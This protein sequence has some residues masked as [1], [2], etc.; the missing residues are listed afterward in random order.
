MISLF[1]SSKLAEP[2]WW[3][4][5]TL[6]NPKIIFSEEHE[7]H[8]QLNVICIKNS[9]VL[10]VRFPIYHRSVDHLLECSLKT[11][12]DYIGM[13]TNNGIQEAVLDL[14]CHIIQTRGG[15]QHW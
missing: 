5:W 15:Q 13:L 10:G 3:C 12:K 7:V 11:A 9:P 6:H 4:S 14:L 1:V 2:L 8:D